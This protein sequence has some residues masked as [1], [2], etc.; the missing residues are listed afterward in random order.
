MARKD[1]IKIKKNP[2]EMGFFEH[3]GEMRNR[4][5]YSL[6][7]VIIMSAV[8]AALIDFTMDS[9]LLKPAYDAKMTLQNLQPFGQP[10]L[11]FKTILICGIILAM[12]IILW[13][14]WLFVSPGLYENEKKWAGKI[15][16]F[17]SLCFFT[18]VAFSYYVMIPSMLAFANNF[19]S[20][21]I[22]NLIDINAYF[23]FFVMILL[24]SGIMFE[25]PMV[26]FIL[27]KFGVV[28]TKFLR[29]YR[30]HSII[31]ILILAAVITPTPDPV[32]QM[33]FAAPL[34]ILY[35]ISILIAKFAEK[36]N[37]KDKS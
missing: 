6:I 37:E 32:T 30:R 31:V 26:I 22:K 25:M 1:K 34:L 5:I 35:E 19:G 27:S 9:V 11:Y 24:A 20:D 18:G 7:A 29:K 3:L 2:E 8:S 10:F 16:F 23:S 28:G 21:S 15:T 13:Q 4:I 17:T 36:N 12:P 33:I 14:V